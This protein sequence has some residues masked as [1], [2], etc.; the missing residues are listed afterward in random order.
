MQQLSGT[1]YTTSEQHKDATQARVA[2]DVKDTQE[3]LRY[4][5]QRSPFT[6]KPSLRN[7]ATGVTAS[8]SVNVHDSKNVGKRILAS[9]EGKTVAEYTFRKRYQA[10]T[11]NVKSTIKVHDEPVHV[12]PQLLF[13]R[14]VTV[15]TKNDELKDV[16]DYE[17]CHYPPAL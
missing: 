12:D 6:D 10:V 1:K 17:L 3:V 9:M 2:R 5:S 7:I 11:M 14:L 15:G 16:F 13:Q 8:P 4:I